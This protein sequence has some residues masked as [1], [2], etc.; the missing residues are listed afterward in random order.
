M[1]TDTR[2]KATIFHCI[3]LTQIDMAAKKHSFQRFS[4]TTIY[5]WRQFIS[6]FLLT[7]LCIC[8]VFS[9]VRASSQLGLNKF[10][11]LKQYLG[12]ASGGDGSYEFKKVTKAMAEK[13]L[14][15]AHDVGASF[16]RVAISGTTP[17]QFGHGGDLD[18]WQRNPE[19]HW[20]IVDE[21]MSALHVRGI[22]IVPVFMWH[23]GQFPAM[24]TEQVDALLTD[25]NSRSWELLKK[26]ISQ[27]IVRYRNNT[28]ILFYELGN[29][30]NLLADLDLDR[31]CKTAKIKMMVCGTR[32]HFTSADLIAFSKRMSELIRSLDSTRKISSGF[33]IP[34]P[35]AE[36]LRQRPELGSKADWTRD[37]MAD[38]ERNLADMHQYVD[39]I[40][41]HLYPGKEGQRFGIGPGE[42]YQLLK[43]LKQASDRIGKPLFVGEF[44]D[45]DARNAKPEGFSDKILDE[46]VNLKIPYAAMW[47]W[48]L[49]IKNTYTSYDTSHTL[50]SLE[51]GNTDYLIGQFRETAAKLR[52]DF[53]KS[54]IPDK[55]PP[56][57]VLTLPLE[58]AKISD[59]QTLYAVA[60]DE[61]KAAE[62]VEFLVNGVLLHRKAK[63][64]YQT[65]WNVKGEKPG[66]YMIT[67]RAFDRAGNQ[68]EYSASV[69]VNTAKAGG[70]V[71]ATAN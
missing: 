23:L 53:R 29:E 67:A 7:F 9:E 24:A 43:I 44:G 26:Y 34:R 49:Y 56:R 5:Y 35:S 39:I 6:K 46:I 19:D 66:E 36:H 13:A 40:S 12:T 45:P 15:D 57:V 14:N 10:E 51:P 41:V 62:K 68:A 3:F 42:E 64:P 25:P 58:C 4:Y 52:S 63:P 54:V 33:A 22:H 20:K 28:G 37:T 69:L 48:Q 8:L 11:L 59:A 61:G 32:A 71:C 16:V 38:L 30:L 2:R 55:I 17:A 60:S 31:R 70:G 21:M 27:F 50:F 18:L 65:S 47:A 1:S